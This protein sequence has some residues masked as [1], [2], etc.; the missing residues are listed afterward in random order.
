MRPALEPSGTDLATGSSLGPSEAD[1][2][3]AVVDDFGRVVRGGPRPAV[4]DDFGWLV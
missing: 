2:E 3:P 1:G 4:V